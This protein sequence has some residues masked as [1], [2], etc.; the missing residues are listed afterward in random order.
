MGT[1]GVEKARTPVG[2]RIT[3]AGLLAFR[4]RAGLPCWLLAE[5]VA[6][7][8]FECGAEAGIVDVLYCFVNEAFFHEDL[9]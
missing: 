5:M 2:F 9:A 4:R 8:C 6:G 7:E 3:P 1:A